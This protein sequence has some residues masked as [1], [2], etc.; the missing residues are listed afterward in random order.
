MKFKYIYALLILGM[1]LFFAPANAQQKK[2]TT[3]TKSKTT[4]KPAVKKPAPK[5]VVKKPAVPTRSAAQNL[6]E[7]ASK[8]AQD[9]SKK[10]GQ[11][12]INNQSLSE[13]IIVTTAYKPVLADAVKIRRNPDLEDKSPFK[14]PLTY[15]PIDKR[16]ERN[17]DIKQME[18][19]KMPAELDSALYN[20]LVKAGAGN[21]KSTFAELYINNGR[22]AAL[23]TG[24]YVKHLAQAGDTYAKQN[25]SRDEIGIFGK[26]VGNVNSLHGTIGYKRQGNYFYGYNKFDPPV[27]AINPAKQ[28]F[29]TLS[30]EGDLTKNFKDVDKDFTYALKLNGY[31][32]NNAFHAKESNVVLSG[33]INQT[34]K[35]FYAGLNASVDLSTQKDSL[36]SIGNNLVRANPYLKFQGENYKIDAGINIVSEFGYS[37]RLFVFPAARLEVQIIPKYVRLFAEA[38]GDVN[39]S[40]LK[41]FSETNPFIGQNI[42]IKNSVDQLDLAAGLKGTLAPGLGFKATVFRND[43]KN[44]PLFISNFNFTNGY[45]RFNVIYDGGKATVTGFNGE[46]D[47]KASDDLDIFGRVEIKDYKM[48]T[49]AQPWNLP[50]FKLSAGTNI[51]I[52]DKV[53]LMGTL[54]FR[55]DTKD[56]VAD[57][58]SGVGA[59]RVVS[60]K[61][62]ADINAGAEY[63][64]NKRLGIFLQANNLLNATYSSWLYYPDYGFNIIGGVSYGF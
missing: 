2:S 48:A 12:G 36:Y 11:N 14:A 17:T 5:P 34:V 42:N 3:K 49:E 51:N 52:S 20:N 23:Q 29:N 59:T 46:L 44:M 64:V 63:K 15:K 45:N 39:K 22:D 7:A 9:T 10:A 57:P 38:K 21:L 56:R 31:L 4:A 53:K 61:S 27:T 19:V 8:I 13:E 58:A 33:F 32:F 18:A 54:L 60:L 47:F 40:S 37:S 43:V 16:L 25:Q 50:K 41:D 35:Q 62:F 1:A 55:G 24:L 28:T 26:S 6:G 30:A